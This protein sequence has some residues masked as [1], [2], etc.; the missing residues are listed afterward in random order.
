MP[1]QAP[2]PTVAP[3]DLAA[4]ARQLRSVVREGLPAVAAGLSPA[5][6]QGVCSGEWRENPLVD[7]A[8]SE[9]GA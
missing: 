8:C 7:E 2:D 4:A 6:I 1:T 9:L 5:E 3:P